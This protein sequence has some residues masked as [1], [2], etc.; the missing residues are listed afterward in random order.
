MTEMGIASSLIVRLQHELQRRPR[1]RAIKIGLRL[2]ERAGLDGDSLKSCVA[3]LAKDAALEPL[4]L[5]IEWCRAAA[6]PCVNEFHL[7][8]LEFEEEEAA[9]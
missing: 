6:G 5:E 2:G 9:S 3:T 1:H 4:A 8:Y 7:S